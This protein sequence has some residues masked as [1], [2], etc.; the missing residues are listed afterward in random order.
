[1]TTRK[2]VSAAA[3]R[4]SLLTGRL[5]LRATCLIPQRPWR[6][7]RSE[8]YLVDT[9]EMRGLTRISRWPW[10]RVSWTVV[11]AFEVT[12]LVALSVTHAATRSLHDQSI[13]LVVYPVSIGALMQWCFRR[14]KPIVRYD[15]T[16]LPI[17]AKFGSVTFFVVWSAVVLLA[18][19]PA[20]RAVL[21]P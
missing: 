7:A 2:E 8:R 19:N 14:R 11:L 13:V 3:Q 12:G 16:R 6:R 5:A 15:A 10:R 1:M 20:S 21:G 9:R 4:G 18:V 17:A